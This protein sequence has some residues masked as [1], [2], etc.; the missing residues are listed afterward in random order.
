VD[1]EKFQ[2]LRA[3]LEKAVGAQ[4]ETKPTDLLYL[5]RLAV[6]DEEMQAQVARARG[7][8]AGAIRHAHTAS[9][10][11]G[12]MPYSFGPPFIDWP[13]AQMLA[14]LLED[15]HDY[16][17]ASAAYATQLVRSR[18]RPAALLGQARSARAQGHSADADDAAAALAVIWHAADP[19]LKARAAELIEPLN[20]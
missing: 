10:L 6:L 19:A 20:R 17:G 15:A 8:G 12:A 13:A 9:E 1:L 16:A 3:E 2:G 18:R 7:D 5:K 14:A 4:A 11:E